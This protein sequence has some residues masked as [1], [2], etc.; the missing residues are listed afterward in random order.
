MNQK[1]RFHISEVTE[2]D[3]HS[4]SRGHGTTRS[5]SRPFK[6]DAS[7]YACICACS[8]PRLPLRT[9]SCSFS[10]WLHNHQT[11]MLLGGL[12]HVPSHSLCHSF[13]DCIAGPHS[14]TYHLSVKY[15]HVFFL[16]RF[17]SER[18]PLL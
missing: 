6:N 9:V 10:S 7:T 15:P 3:Q 18:V 4:S 11:V 8:T 17:D 1:R 2:E 12:V 16:L 13:V 5:T 14:G